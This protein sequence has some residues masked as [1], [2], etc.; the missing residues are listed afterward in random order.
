MLSESRTELGKIAIGKEVIATLAGA[1]A[2]EGYGLVG[3]ASRRITDGFVELL[4]QENWSRGVEVKIDGDN[5]HI[6]LHVIV[7]YGVRI[8]EVAKNV[9]ERVKYAVEDVTGLKVAR[10]DVHVQ[11]V[12][13]D[14]ARAGV[15]Q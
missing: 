7:N 2:M 1:A 14:M 12:Q 13:I 10:V 15:K 3:M 8:S 6:T 5:V 9:M 4:G 11:G